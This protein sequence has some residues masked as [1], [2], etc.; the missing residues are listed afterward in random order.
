MNWLLIISLLVTLTVMAA[1]AGFYQWLGW[2]RAA[3]ARLHASNTPVESEL[4]SARGLTGQVNRRLRRIGYGERLERQLVAADSK[5][6]AGEFLIT[7]VAAAL[8]GAVIGFLISGNPVGGLLLGI[9]GW[10]IPGMW[11]SRK[12]ASRTKLFADQLPDMLTMLT[13]SLRSGYGFLYA[14]TLIEKEM[15][16]PIAGEFGRVIRET[17]LGYSIGDA[18]DHLVE[19]V[20]NDDLALVVTAVHIQNEVGGSL[21]EVLETISRTIRERIEL[22][23]KIQSLTAQQRATGGLLSGL[24]FAVGTLIFLMSPD[25]MST[26]LQ[27]GWPMLIPVVATVMVIMGNIVMQK[28]TAIDV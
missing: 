7:R 16:E 27:P 28:V 15:P 12:L 25:Y 19:R 26:I 9:V 14:M 23:G 18:L 6:S 8:G 24:P 10:I 20:Q 2:T 3:E 5:M 22:K 11:L 21:A 13:G 17:A 1:M 4:R